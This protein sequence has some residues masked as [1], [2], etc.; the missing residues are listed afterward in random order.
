MAM[1]KGPTLVIVR[2][3]GKARRRPGW[4]APIVPI[5]D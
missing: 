4:S 3:T 1:E 5:I 2:L